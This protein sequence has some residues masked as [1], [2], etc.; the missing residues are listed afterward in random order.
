M[1]V[2]SKKQEKKIAEFATLAKRYYPDINE[3]SIKGAIRY[4]VKAAIKKVL[5]QIGKK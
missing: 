4:G 2:G 1:I 5:F 3:L